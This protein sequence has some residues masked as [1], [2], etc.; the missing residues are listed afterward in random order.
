MSPS[1]NSGRHI[2]ID[3]DGPVTEVLTLT[4]GQCVQLQPHLG[5]AELPA[6]E[7][8]PTKGIFTFLDVLLGGAALVVEPHDPLRFHRQVG[9]D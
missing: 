5:V 9:D 8:C 2:A 4:L 3:S 1:S 6:G 7:P